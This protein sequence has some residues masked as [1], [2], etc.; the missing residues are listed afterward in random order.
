MR[1][2]WLETVLE[3]SETGERVNRLSYEVCVLLALR[4]RLRSKEVWVEGANRYRNPDEES[5]Q[6]LR[7]R[8]CESLEIIVGVPE[9][10]GRV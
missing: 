2:P 9:P 10:E 7:A 4:E 3:E 5:S 1:G 6:R 8:T